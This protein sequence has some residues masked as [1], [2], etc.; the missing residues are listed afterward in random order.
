MLTS[1]LQFDTDLFLMINQDM[2]NVVF[3]WLMPQ[4]RN[5]Y[6]WAPLYLFILIF[7]IKTYK[8]RGVIMML[9]LVLSFGVADFVSASVIK[10][11]LKRVRP[12]NEITL[13][14]ETISRIR[15]GSGFSFPSSHASN[16]F[17]M[18]IFLIMMFKNRWHSILWIG[19]L[20]AFS[21]SFAQI[22]VGVHYPLDVLGGALLGALIGY[23]MASIF[24][25]VQPDQKNT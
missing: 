4:L 7:S 17:A 9:F 23:A 16:H 10:P 13:Q 14:G 2:T 15:C 21:I 22:Y 6:T 1:I 18:A 12:C 5:P 25:R 11:N 24:W 19:L 3:D 8:R 20:W